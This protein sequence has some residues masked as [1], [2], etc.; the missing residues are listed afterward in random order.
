MPASGLHGEMVCHRL[1]GWDSLEVGL[2]AE[3]TFQNMLV[4]FSLANVV[5]Y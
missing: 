5:K 4:V 1:V 3:Q 2:V